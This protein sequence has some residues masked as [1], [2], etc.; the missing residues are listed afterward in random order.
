MLKARYSDSAVADPAVAPPN[1]AVLF[2]QY[3]DYVVYL[4]RKNGIW[5]TD[6]EDVAMDILLRFYEVDGLARYN[7]EAV[8]EKAD[9]PTPV[10]AKFR[11][12][13][14]SFVR[15]YVQGKRERQMRRADRE[16]IIC[17]APAPRPNQNLSWLDVFGDVTEFQSSLEGDETKHRAMVHL[18]KLPQRGRRDLVKLYALVVEKV[19]QGEYPL[20]KDLS[21]ELGVSGTAIG[22][23]F[24]DLRLAV[25]ESLVT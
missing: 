6:C 1:Y 11:T 24:A 8:F 7:P 2:E 10:P 23:M 15:T 19:E 13:L 18:D 21:A 4:V 16:F 17:D 5:K 22:H 14:I 3:Y 25:A 20:R 9:S 12:F